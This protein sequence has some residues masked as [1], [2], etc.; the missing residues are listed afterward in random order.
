MKLQ[1]DIDV[2]ST[3]KTNTIAANVTSTVLINWQRKK[4]E[5]AIFLNTVL[6]AMMLILIITI[7]YYH[8][9]VRKGII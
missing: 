1:L 7:I 8:Y 4:Q 2:A 9:A 5:V 6:L 3:K